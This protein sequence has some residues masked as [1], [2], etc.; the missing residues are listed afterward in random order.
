MESEMEIEAKINK[1]LDLLLKKMNDWIMRTK[2]PEMKKMEEM[3]VEKK[4]GDVPI[5]TVEV[6]KQYMVALESVEVEDS[7][8]LMVLV[9]IDVGCLRL[10]LDDELVALPEEDAQNIGFH[11]ITD[12]VM[13]CVG[14]T[15]SVVDCV[16]TVSSS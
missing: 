11:D 12:S 7:P 3:K 5:Y 16:V 15:D 9:V 6:P 1:E 8:P 13:D 14:V 4:K 10:N 2:A